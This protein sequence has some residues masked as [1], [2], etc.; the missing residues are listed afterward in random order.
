[1]ALGVAAYASK[2]LINA[3]VRWANAPP[4]MRAFYKARPYL[5]RPALTKPLSALLLLPVTLLSWNLP[6]PC[7]W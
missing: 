4:K 7:G 1:M 5:L 6:A 3:G 2:H